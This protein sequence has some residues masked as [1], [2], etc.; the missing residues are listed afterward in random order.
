MVRVSKQLNNMLGLGVGGCATRQ[1]EAHPKLVIISTK[2]QE[3]S[4]KQSAVEN[5]PYLRGR[6]FNLALKYF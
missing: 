1:V 2:L 4:S 3:C 6:P 5:L